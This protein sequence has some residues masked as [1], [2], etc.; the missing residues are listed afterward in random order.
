MRLTDL[1]VKALQPPEKG[2]KIHFDDTQPNF[3]IRLSHGGT[4][5]W[6]VV[7][8]ENRSVRTV[9]RYP[10][11]SL[12]DARKEARKLLSEPQKLT[13]R[14]ATFQEAQTAFL[15]ECATR[16]SPGTLRDYRYH[17]GK[18]WKFGKRP[19]S[20]IAAVEVR[21]KLAD[22]HDR[23][24]EQRYAFS[25][26]RAFF[27]WA[28]R[29]QLTTT[30]PID[31]MKSPSSPKSRDRV[32]TDQEL[33]AVYRAAGG[34]D[35]PFGPIVQLLILTGQRRSEIAGLQWEWI[36]TDEQLITFPAEMVKN[37]TQHFVPLG[38][39]ASSIIQQLPQ[40]TSR[41][42][43]PG[44]DGEKP[45]NGINK[46]KARLDKLVTDVE[47][48]TLHDLR[49]TFASNLARLGTPVHVTEKL[50]NHR[51]GTIS[52]VAAVYNRYD[53]LSERREAVQGYERFIQ[54]ITNH[55]R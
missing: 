52:G 21:Q 12:R 16:L 41:Y 46:A 17:L 40:F 33:G 8:G 7:V 5:S 1:S 14:T 19:L 37:R 22:L 3:G 18:H 10:A 43:F 23:P 45:Y 53:Y 34:F 32:L 51:S 9:G 42:V 13:E 44:K 15:D 49:R 26:L 11:M 55:A 28:V 25:T 38:D 39:M 47:P 31:S 6:V 20:D 30:N 2:Q 27:N 50:L 54:G 24:A 29:N 36:D 4:R 35:F 48:Y